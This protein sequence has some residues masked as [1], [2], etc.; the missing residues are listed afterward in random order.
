MNFMF[1]FRCLVYG[2]FLNLLVKISY[3]FLLPLLVYVINL[4]IEWN[5][6][7]C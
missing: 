3:V 7:F 1:I 2:I 5:I 6:H 4:V